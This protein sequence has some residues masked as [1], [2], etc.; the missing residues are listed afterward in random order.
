M[1]FTFDFSRNTKNLN[2]L[3]KLD[4]LCIKH[5]L[6]PS[7]IKDSRLSSNTIKK[8]YND[9]EIFKKNLS[10]FDKEKTYRS[11]LSDRIGI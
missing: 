8:C 6:K 4:F 7:I 2:F 5:K 9:F 10:D 1:C 11:E 3:D